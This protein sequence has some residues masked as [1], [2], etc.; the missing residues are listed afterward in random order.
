MWAYG[1]H[2]HTKYVDDGHITQD[3][4]VEVQF[5][6]SSHASH[7]DQNLIE[8][9]LGYI[10]KIQEIM[11]V[12][13]SSF[14]CVIFCCKWWDTF[15]RRNVKED[16]DSGLICMNSKKMWVETKEPYVFPK[17][18]NQVFLYPDVLDGD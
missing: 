16:R 3:C 18:C 9:K 8:G 10:G 14:Q 5:D 12:D 13:F 2:F 1:H 15:D 17:H 7:H 6:Q 4:G 11:K